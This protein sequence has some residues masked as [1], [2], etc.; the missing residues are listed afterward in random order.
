MAPLLLLV[1]TL[2][3][4]LWQRS[5]VLDMWAT[6]MTRP[7]Y[8]H[9]PILPVL[10][11]WLLWRER[12]RFAD[13]SATQ[14]WL[15]LPV[16]GLG[17]AI[18]ML[19]NFAAI[20]S[21]V[22]YGVAIMLIGLLAVAIGVRNA[23]RIW[24]ASVLL[25]LMVP[26]PNFLL[27]N[28]S[29]DLQLLSSQIGVALLRLINISVYLEGNV[30]DLG[31]LK[32]QVAEACDGMRYLF[33]LATIA[34]VLA[35]FYSAPVWK[36][37]VLF[38][39]SI[40]ITIA[41][42]SLRIA[43]IGVLVEHWGLGLARGFLHE[44]QGW[45]VF[46]LCLGLLLL[47]IRLLSAAGGKS[48]GHW[49]DQLALGSMSG[50]PSVT[51]ESPRFRASAAVLGVSACA[52]A[53]AL[54]GQLVPQR[55]EAALP[56]Q[57]FSE[58]PMRAGEWRGSRQSIEQA[59]LDVL[60][61]DDYLLGNFTPSNRQGLVNFYVAY[62]ES[63]RTGQ[64]AH[65]PRSCIPGGGWKIVSI[66][67]HLLQPK[68]DTRGFQVNRVVI[69]RDADRQVLYYWFSQRGRTITNEYA[70]KWYIFWDAV[71]RNRTDGAMIRIAAPMLRG[72]TVSDVD[73]ELTRF[74]AQ[75][76]PTLPEFIPG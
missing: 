54:A 50:T 11:I 68:P 52:V 49:R 28:L 51:Q 22:Q 12:R 10:A 29:V 7:E 63:Q 47:E 75:V 14:Q 62:Y 3:T 53:V 59:Y 19:G 5:A 42:N 2:A 15:A 72:Q 73:R 38:L 17:A 66:E 32:L 27:N 33:P 24:I 56:R 31:D 20:Y 65:S 39:S 64:S 9:G 13:V 41:M 4:L 70:V 36:K 37:A 61:L 34:F 25:L 6:W 18:A 71:T 69:E 21:L 48:A 55:V 46:M 8:S 60:Q 45:L 35:Y 26:L 16:Y 30:I 44:F 76:L 40:P 67:P 57:H 1:A 58:F 43:T 74:A 23:R